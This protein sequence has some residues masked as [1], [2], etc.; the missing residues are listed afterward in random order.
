M[1]ITVK[2]Q[3]DGAPLVAP[4]T[5]LARIR[6]VVQRNGNGRSVADEVPGVHFF[7][8]GGQRDDALPLH[9]HRRY[10]RS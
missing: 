3:P 4:G 7:E 1:G 10:H 5:T 8:C 6:E 9:A 2:P